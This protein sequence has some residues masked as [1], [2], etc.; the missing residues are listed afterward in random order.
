MTARR[1][2]AIFVHA[3]DELLAMIKARMQLTGDTKSATCRRLIR[4]GLRYQ[5]VM[6]SRLPV[7]EHAIFDLPSNFPFMNKAS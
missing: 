7:D 2:N 1:E 6:E 4:M 3:D 5:Q